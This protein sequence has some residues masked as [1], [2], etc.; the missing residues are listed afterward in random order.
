MGE[1]EQ[2]MKLREDIIAR[3]DKFYQDG[4]YG[5]F[6]L[7][8]G[9]SYMYRMYM[10]E[11]L[12]SLRTLYQNNLPLYHKIV[13]AESNMDSYVIGEVPKHISTL[14][15]TDI[16]PASYQL[17]TR[18]S[19]ELNTEQLNYHLNEIEQANIINGFL[20]TYHPE[21]RNLYNELKED[22]RIIYL[23]KTRMGRATPGL[24]FPDVY[25]NNKD[26]VFVSR[27][28]YNY[29]LCDDLFFINIL[30]HELGH[31]ME[32]RDLNKQN[33]ATPK[34]INNFHLH[35]FYTETNS[36]LQEFRYADFLKRYGFTKG[37]SDGV[38]KKIVDSVLT[39]PAQL[40]QNPSRLYA[41][42]SSNMA[43]NYKEC[44]KYYYG[45]I[46][47]LYLHGLDEGEFREK[48]DI[49]NQ[50]KL[51]DP[52]CELLGKINCNTKNLVKSVYGRKY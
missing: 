49:Y 48:M 3:A 50:A 1:F 31:L 39:Y 35:S 41:G 25:G 27:V 12:F 47:S 24:S 23:D 13:A 40:Q 2:L 38:K 19:S 21:H 46:C 16:L 20:A 30:L 34:E 42:F 4:T 5:E 10:N 22:G 8:S 11:E 6:S 7:L 51:V 32:F 29:T 44:L 28:A 45:S 14:Q 33:F 37:I 52:N 26:Y 43:Y 9:I 36:I 15:Q 17:F 18:M